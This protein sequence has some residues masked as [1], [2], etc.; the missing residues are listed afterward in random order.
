MKGIA[1]IL[2][3]GLLLLGSS[4]GPGTDPIRGQV[5]IVTKGGENVK[6][7]LVTVALYSESMIGQHIEKRNEDARLE[8]EAAEFELVTARER[9]ATAKI[10]LDEAIKK[11][12]RKEG[13]A[14]LSI[15]HH[16]EVERLQSVIR[17]QESR[18][19]EFNTAELYFVA[20]PR[21]LATAETDADGD[22][23]IL[24]PRRGKYIL[25]ARADR[26]VSNDVEIYHW[27]VRVPENARRGTKLLLSNTTMTNSGSPLSLVLTRD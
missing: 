4:H 7:G 20:M 14:T 3:L 6:L 9:L 24:I 11:V 5:F 16:D 19:R 22:F 26:H 18:L 13:N 15:Q 17:F 12:A 27:L 25:A 10:L 2:F 21:P 23:K 1:S 8:A